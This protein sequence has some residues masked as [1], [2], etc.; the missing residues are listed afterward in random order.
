ME[1]FSHVYTVFE[2]NLRKNPEKKGFFHK[3]KG[4][5]VSISYREME[6]KVIQLSTYF[7]TQLLL[8][9]GDRIALMS[10]NCPQWALVDLATLHFSGVIVPIY[11][12]L[13]VEEVAYIV[14]D[15]GAKVLVLETEEMVKS[16]QSLL[17]L[18]PTLTTLISIQSYET[19]HRSIHCLEGM[20]RFNLSEYRSFFG[21]DAT[22][23]AT[24]VYTS[25]TTG[26]PKGVCLSHENIMT[27]VCDIVESLNLDASLRVLSFLPLSHAF[28]RTAGYYTVLAVGGEIYYA[29]SMDTISA[30]LQLAQPTGVVS[31]PRLY[32]K[33]YN[34]VMDGSAFKRALI[35]RASHVGSQLFRKSKKDYS[36]FEWIQYRLYSMLVY[37]KFKRL[38]GGRLQFFV[39]GGAP[40]GKG[41]GE[42]FFSMG[43]FIIE[44]YGMTETSPVICCNRFESF[45]FGSVGL[46]LPHVSVALA[47]DGELLVKG[48]SVM[49]EYY[50]NPEKTK[51]II[52]DEG[53][54]HTG[55][56]ATIDH[57]GF[58][59]I[60]D[61]K[62][63]IIVLSN[64]K[65]IP[66]QPIES[67][68]LKSRYVDQAIVIGDKR[69]YV[70]ALIV[71]NVNALKRYAAE[72]NM[73]YKSDEDLILS[74]EARQ[75]IMADLAQYQQHDARYK[76]VKKVRCLENPFTQES[77]ELTP[78][79]KPKRR[80][81]QER[82]AHIIDAMYNE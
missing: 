59:Y 42:F 51:E 62:K 78:T 41:L 4:S 40:L 1:S 52:D 28:E 50:R 9:K 17:E 27:N 53:W 6:E 74:V 82:Y 63:D 24:I 3:E 22:E 39:S 16:C 81:I 11:P 26:N 70:T 75:W 36:W 23:L 68:I 8:Q 79:L 47:Q 25:G 67:E 80:L 54:L 49:M 76:H 55:D 64:G 44:G 31:V 71:P 10:H 29:E 15:S 34:K 12:S 43:L 37:S 57:E 69:N 77:G 35:R 56:V 61:R 30:D 18:C 19:N 46:P 66:P 33:I 2:E 7:Q 73:T 32:E 58:V 60:V 14:T 21:C 65:N 20:L 45:R 48:K 5:F 13:T 38:T 72:K